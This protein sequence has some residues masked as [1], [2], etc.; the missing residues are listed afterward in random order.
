MNL[1]ENNVVIG[2]DILNGDGSVAFHKESLIDISKKEWESQNFQVEVDNEIWTVSFTLN[3][4]SLNSEAELQQKLVDEPTSNILKINKNHN[5]GGQFIC[6]NGTRELWLYDFKENTLSH[7]LGHGF[8]LEHS[9]WG[10]NN[11]LFQE[12]FF[13]GPNNPYFGWDAESKGSSRNGNNETSGPNMSYAV[14]TSIYLYEVKL[15]VQDGI[16]LSKSVNENNVTIHIKSSCSD[17]QTPFIIKP[18]N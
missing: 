3:F 15:I 10:P 14:N 17:D 8:G 6:D 7:E 12:Y 16:R 5:F 4:V 18:N 1:I 13:S 11:F 2:Y 9:E